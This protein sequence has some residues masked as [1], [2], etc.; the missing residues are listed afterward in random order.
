MTIDTHAQM[1]FKELTR[2]SIMHQLV[3]QFN[4]SGYQEE[5]AD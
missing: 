4:V 5:D 2:G 3:I 1:L